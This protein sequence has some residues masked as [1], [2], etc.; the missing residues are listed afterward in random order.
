MPGTRHALRSTAPMPRARPRSPTSS[1]PP[2]RR[3]DAR[4][5]ERR[6]TASTA[7]AASATGGEDS[8]RGYLEDSLDRVRY[9]PGQRLYLDEALA[10]ASG[11]L[12]LALF[13]EGRD[14]LLRVLSRGQPAERVRLADEVLHMVALEHVVD[15]D[16][17]S[18]EGQRALRSERRGHLTDAPHP[19]PRLVNRANETDPQR[20]AGVDRAPGENQVLRHAQPADAREPL[21]SAPAGDE[22]EADLGLA[23]LRLRGRVAGVARERELA[24]AAQCEPVDG[25]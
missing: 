11:E 14:A 23:E 24:A 22:A 12:R 4:P 5:S 3:P 8:P 15:S 19:P 16:L 9:L 25:R 18:G 20:L 21:G 7:R 10:S 2:W 17:R 1:Q 6:S 13:G